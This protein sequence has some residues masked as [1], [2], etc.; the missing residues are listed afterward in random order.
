M[1]TL[2]LQTV[3]AVIGGAIGGPFGAM[4]G[5]ALGAYAGHAIDSELFGEKQTVHGARLEQ[6]R[7][8]A[9]SDGAPMPKAYGRVRIGGQVIWATRFEEIASTERQGGKGGGNS[10]VTVT[11]YSYLANFAVGICEG[12]IACIRRIWADGQ[13][14]DQTR[15]EIRL[16]HGAEDQQPDPLIDAK[17]GAG[18]APAYRGV[19]YVVFEAFPLAEFGNR[20]PQLSFEVIRTVGVLDRA[21]RAVTVIPGATEFGYAPDPVRHSAGG[22]VNRNNLMAASDWTASIDELAAL[23]PALET[24]ALV[25]SWFGDDLRAGECHIAPRVEFTGSGGE[26]WSVAGVGRSGCAAVS[27]IDDRPAYG[28]TPADSAVLAAIADLKARGLKVVLYP[29]VMMDIAAGNLLPDPY[30]G[31]EQAAYPW[32][33]AIT[34]YPAAGQ[35]GTADRTFASRQ[36]VALFAGTAAAGD[37]AFSGSGFSYSGPHEWRYRRMILHHAALARA[38]GGVDGFVIGS[39]LVGLTRLRDQ[40]DAFAFVE[41][42]CAIANEA[43]AILGPDTK[44]TYGADW[45]EY[46]GYRPDDGSGDVYFNLDPLW[47][48]EA[49]D[50]VGIDNYMPL[51]DWR[52]E[53]DPGDGTIR[54]QAGLGY[55]TANIEGGEGYDWYYASIADRIAGDRTAI[56]D[57][58]GEDWIWRFKDIRSWWL[59]SHYQRIGGQRQSVPTAWQPRSKPFWFT[60]LGCAAVT[61]GANQPNVFA[62]PKSEQGGTPW[63]STGARADHVQAR[64]LTAHHAWWSDPQR[65]PVSPLYGGAMVD[66]ASIFAWAWDARPFPRFPADLDIW[67]DGVNWHTG[68][69]LNGRLGGC[70]LDGLIAAIAADYGVEVSADCAGF[71]DGYLVSGPCSARD[72]IEPL[73]ALFSLS[74]REQ[75]AITHI[76]DASYGEEAAIAAADIAAA[77][78]AP[79]IVLGREPASALPAQLSLGHAGLFCDYESR[80]SYSRRVGEGGNPMQ[81]LSLPLVLP[82]SMAAGALETALRERWTARETLAIG[83]PH[84]FAALCPGDCLRLEG[85]AGDRLWRIER[86]EDGAFRRLHLRATGRPELLPAIAEGQPGRLRAMA[87]YAA[88]QFVLMNLPV[89]PSTPDIHVH[90]ALAA[91]PWAKLYAIRSSPGEDGFQLRETVSGRAIAG[92]L[93]EALAPGVEGRWDDAAMLRVILSGGALESRETAHVLN[94]AN[95]AAIEAA[96]GEWE[97]VQ[98]RS[99]TLLDDGSWRLSR[100]LRGQIGTDPAMQAGSAA[101]SRFVLLDEGVKRIGLGALEAGLELNWLAGPVFSPLASDSQTLCQH[102]HED[103]ARRPL[104]PV[105][106]RGERDEHGVCRFH[107]IRRSRIASD[108]WDAAEIPLGEIDERYR[109]SILDAGGDTLRVVETTTRWAEYPPELEFADFGE[110]QAQ[111]RI[112]VAQIGSAGLA[113][114]GRAATIHL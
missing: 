59:S 31:D 28:G 4:L 5:R 47:V 78:D 104:S 39:E 10:G 12:E 42:L 91:D 14:I 87:H 30:G 107:W 100:L 84:R 106:L 80:H 101:G 13:E 35:P 97:I 16:Y 66:S 111:L 38:A 57:H 48:D 32:R 95:A 18:N 92:E 64:F 40:N 79:L 74:C 46:F 51:S 24:V 21:I 88:P 105:H 75:D 15:Y 81:S 110:T 44:I 70:P 86:I 72:A 45:S 20:I 19:A 108:S 43:R 36:Q 41:Q 96:N 77:D 50:A 25:V 103:M 102:R 98:F 67:S 58:L 83:L 49:I 17:Q 2:L 62:D 53:G 7:I 90:A 85:D 63:F 22:L 23:C 94:G 112:A 3:G 60:E 71:V 34:C 65:N 29:F 54:S 113:G 114:A 93:A 55:L 99:A 9:S 26:N 1:A 73:T 27:R 68:H 33:G 52:G 61:M 76:C 89:E 11:Q 69:W 56:S 6:A 37:Y 109:L 82:D 8:M